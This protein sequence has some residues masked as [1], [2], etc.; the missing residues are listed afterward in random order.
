MTLLPVVGRELR[1]ASRRRWSYWGRTSAAGAALLIVA[2]FLLIERHGS[3][4]MLGKGLFATTSFFAALFAGFAGVLYSADSLAEERREGTLGLL[5]L[6][7]L[8]GYDVLFGKMAASSLGA[9]FHM[10]SCFPV[11]AIALLMGGVTGG[12]YVRMLGFL[13]LLLLCSLSLGM[14]AST[15]GSNSRAAGVAAFLLNLAMAAGFP[16]LGGIVYWIAWKFEVP[17][18]VRDSWF[19]A[20]FAWANPVAPF[21]AAFDD[22][23][24]RKPALYWMGILFLGVVT[25]G[26]LG[27]GMIRLPRIW[28]ERTAAKV[29]RGFVG[30]LEHW[31][32]PTPEKR[33]AWCARLLAMS[34]LV[35]LAGRHWMRRVS[36]W[37]F[38]VFAAALFGVFALELGKDFLEPPSFIVTSIL[39]HLVVKVWVAGEAP[40]MFHEDRTSGGLEL[41][42]STPMTVSDFTE[43]C[44]RALRRQFEVPIL[45]VL[46]VDFAFMMFGMDWSSE[47]DK[48]HWAGFWISRILLLPLDAYAMAWTG[49][50]VA[51]TTRGNR[52]T[53]HVILRILVIPW[54]IVFALSTLAAVASLGGASVFSGLGFGG[55]LTVWLLLCAGNDVFWIVQAR[56]RLVGFRELATTKLSPRAAKA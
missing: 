26:A 22:E 18:S 47:P 1:V 25:V 43:G 5:F 12:E 51:M 20:G 11:M 2:W 37:T 27:L 46:A 13:F 6:T 28:Q 40:R 49:M 48:G 34:P 35:W 15:F 21:I 17:E 45:V 3:I 39:V 32:W 29:K 56:N 42:L 8:K 50:S 16:A 31:R 38:L 53:V 19:E 33:Q 55:A 7:D 10:L 4:A 30:R 44:L 52:T 41:L 54:L 36:L 14:L 24:G 9:F 23:F